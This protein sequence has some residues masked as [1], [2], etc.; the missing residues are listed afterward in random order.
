M[1]TIFI[2]LPLRAPENS[3]SHFGPLFISAALPLLERIVLGEPGTVPLE[4]ESEGGGPIGCV[5]LVLP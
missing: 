4:L 5:D 3:D 1:V 2:D